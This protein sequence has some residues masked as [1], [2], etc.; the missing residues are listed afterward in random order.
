MKYTISKETLSVLVNEHGPTI[1]CWVLAC[2]ERT[3][4]NTGEGWSPV[5]PPFSL[6]WKEGWVPDKVRPPMGPPFSVRGWGP[7]STPET[8]PHLSTAPRHN[9]LGTGPPME[10]PTAAGHN[11]EIC[12]ATSD[13]FVQTSCVRANCVYAS[14][15]CRLLVVFSFILSVYTVSV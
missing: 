14:G 11:L 5:H 15:H 13:A 10:D 12:M 2:E 1:E 8:H 3:P 4:D 7:E 9:R 6:L